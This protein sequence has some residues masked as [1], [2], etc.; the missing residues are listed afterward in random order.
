MRVAVLGAGLQGTCAAFELALRGVH[1]DLFDRHDDALCGTSGRNEGKLHLGFVYAADRSL[2]TARLMVRAAAC[3]EPNLRR[4]L[5]SSIDAVAPSSPFHY[6]VHRDSLIAPDRIRSHLGAC[7]DL[8]LAHPE[9]K[10]GGYFGADFHAPSRELAAAERDA[11]FDGNTV[12]TAFLTPEIA[13]DPKALAVIVRRHLRSVHNIALRF[14]TRVLAVR[15]EDRCATVEFAHGDVRATETYDHV[16]NALW[17]G[18]LAIDATAGIRPERPW[19]WRVKHFMRVRAAARTADVPSTTVVLGPFGDV[20]NYAGGDLYLSWYPESCPV[21]SAGLD[22]PTAD[23]P[24]APALRAR[25]RAAMPQAL[26]EIVPAVGRLPPDILDDA[27]IDGG[28]IFAWGESDVDD[29]ASALHQRSDI[30]VRS[31]GR[32]HS[33]DTGKYITAPLFAADVAARILSDR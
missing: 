33:I 9:P 31:R 12:A 23:L 19:L 2:R 14:D 21:R 10:G 1:V 18:R 16:I 3:F 30:G 25:L 28:I 20:V 11:L 8:A 32:Y 4:W 26:A 7:R 6:V 17:D 24:A 27:D 13:I 22:A 29:P 5:G 15:A